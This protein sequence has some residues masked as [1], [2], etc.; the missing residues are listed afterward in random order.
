[1]QFQYNDGGRQ[2]TGRKGSAGDCVARSIAIVS[3]LD[4]DYVYKELAN[5]RGTECLWRRDTAGTPQKVS[6]SR[7]ARNGINTKSKWFKEWMVQHGFEWTPTMQIGVGCK[8]H[9]ADGEL[10]DGRLVV[11]VSKHYT[12]VI[13]GVINDTFDPQRSVMWYGADGKLDRVSERCVYGYWR[14]NGN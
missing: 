5:G 8:V 6:R 10:P 7:S 13:D 4:Y 3:G 14:Y 1:M 12:A 9:L 2:E 11:A